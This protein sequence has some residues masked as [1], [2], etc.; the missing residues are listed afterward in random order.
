VPVIWHAEVANAL[1][2]KERQKR[3]GEEVAREML[4]AL[5][6][7]AVTVDLRSAEA[8]FVST[9]LLAR[10]HRLSVYDA[11]YLELAIRESLPLATTDGALRR[12]ATSAGVTLF[13]LAASTAALA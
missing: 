6:D 2:V 12:A 7:L 4:R 8:V 1:V 10:Q 3:L 5:D 13:G 11:M 9:V